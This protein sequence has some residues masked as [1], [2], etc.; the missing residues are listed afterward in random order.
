MRLMG[1]ASICASSIA[2]EFKEAAFAGRS[3]VIVS[4]G[5]DVTAVFG[6]DGESAELVMTQARRIVAEL[7]E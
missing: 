3:L 1:A 2:D 4:D 7:V 6:E 5:Q